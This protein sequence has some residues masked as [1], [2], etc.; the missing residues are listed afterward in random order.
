MLKT[1]NE[2]LAGWQDYCDRNWL[3]DNGEDLF[4]PELRVKRLLDSIGYFLLYG[5][6]EG[7]VSEYKEAV[8]RAREIPVSS[9]PSAVSNMM[10]A[11]GGASGDT[12]AEER[13]SFKAM[14]EIL[15]DQVRSRKP[16]KAQK[17]QRPMSLR[18]KICGVREQQHMAEPEYFIVDTFGCFDW[19]GEIYRICDVPEYHPKVVHFRNGSTELI[20]DMDRIIRCGDSWYNMNWDPIPDECIQLSSDDF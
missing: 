8:N 15:D 10:Y 2:I 18:K 17:E 9:C 11:G 12:A 4:S 6:T 1:A 5:N 3:N 7:V 14:T 19:R 13:L 16:A 20:Y